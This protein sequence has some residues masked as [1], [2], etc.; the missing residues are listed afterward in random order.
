MDLKV[1]GKYYFLVIVDLA[2]RFCTEAVIRAVATSNEYDNNSGFSPNQLVFG[3]NPA[4]PNIY[5]N[6][7]QGLENVT[8]S[9]IVRRNLNA[10][11]ITRQD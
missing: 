2:T 4:I 9:E 8:I 7:L 11:H 10:V 3:F 1:W 6:K 5:N